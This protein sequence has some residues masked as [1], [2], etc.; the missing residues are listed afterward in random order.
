MGEIENNMVQGLSDRLQKHAVTKILPEEKITQT[1]KFTDAEF[2]KRLLSPSESFQHSFH[3][4]KPMNTQVLTTRDPSRPPGAWFSHRYR[5]FTRPCPLRYEC[6]TDTPSLHVGRMCWKRGTII[7][8]QLAL[9]EGE[10][11]SER[12]GDI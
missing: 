9:G 11:V 5:E 7:T 8:K 12:K 10:S 1:L 3:N 2:P 4:T 6:V